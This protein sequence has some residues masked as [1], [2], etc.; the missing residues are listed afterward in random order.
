MLKNDLCAKKELEKKIEEY[1]NHIWYNGFKE[2]VLNTLKMQM[3]SEDVYQPVVINFS[4]RR[5]CSKLEFNDFLDYIPDTT[6]IPYVIKNLRSKLWNEGINL[7]YDSLFN[8][9]AKI[10]KDSDKYNDCLFFSLLN[11][12]S[13]YTALFM[14]MIASN[15]TPEEIIDFFFKSDKTNYNKI[16]EV[17]IKTGLVKEKIKE[18]LK[19]EKKKERKKEKGVKTQSES[20]IDDAIVSASPE[21]K[22]IINE[23]KTNENID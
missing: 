9:Y 2:Y 12:G 16:M 10:K 21:V 6:L 13:D 8:T 14:L 18:D 1:F 7:K 5:Y 23:I 22:E 3:T 11:F 19:A 4:K 20:V 15:K 17:A